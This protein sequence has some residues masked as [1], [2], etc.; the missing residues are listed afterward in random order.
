MSL[1]LRRDFKIAAGTLKR[2]HIILLGAL[3]EGLAAS[4]LSQGKNKP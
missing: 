2:K 4:W 1:P 3:G